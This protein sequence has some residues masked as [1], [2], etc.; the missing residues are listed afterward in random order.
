MRSVSLHMKV[1]VRMAKLV[2][3]S[4]TF[5][6]QKN[7]SSFISLAMWLW[8]SIWVF[9]YLSRH[10]TVGDLFRHRMN[11][12]WPH[13]VYSTCW[14]CAINSNQIIFY[15]SLSIMFLCTWYLLKIYDSYLMKYLYC[16]VSWDFK[17]YTTEYMF[18]DPLIN[19]EN[20][21]VCIKMFRDTIN[22][23]LS[24]LLYTRI[25]IFMYAVSIWQ[26]PFGVAT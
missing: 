15:P 16:W 20:Q 22:W 10:Y 21:I 6:I 26:I 17:Q 7:K 19:R 3:A 25:R 5:Y 1:R 14:R 13:D 9:C 23:F 12:L 4:T 8:C 24:V 18:P 2:V 11:L